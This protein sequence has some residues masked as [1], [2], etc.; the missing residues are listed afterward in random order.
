V[1]R[2]RLRFLLQEIDLPQGETLIGRS[3]SCQVTIEDP[4]VSRQH[5]RLYIQGTLAT[6]ED[7]GS[8]NGSMV[9]GRAVSGSVQ[10]RDGDRIRIGTQDL[11]LCTVGA[12]ARRA[13]GPGTRPTGFMCHCADCSQ[14]YPAELAMCPR[15]GATERIDEDT[16][17]G[18]VGE[19]QRNWSLELLI[20]VLERA[21]SLGRWDDS[22]RVLNRAKPH[23]EERLAAS[24]PLTREQVAGLTKAASRLAEARG[25]AEWG[26]WALALHAALGSVPPPSV[27]THLS[28]LPGPERELLADAVNDVVESV[29][30][31]G[32]PKLEDK[33]DF[34]RVQSLGEAPAGG[35][36]E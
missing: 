17:S 22:E 12:P 34:A 14:P 2:Y 36:C 21:V 26:R 25:K 35:D 33:A 32:G 28:T 9:N 27:T 11:V 7:L 18:V 23:V 19:A 5:G 20:E 10:V 16:I 3:A 8:R 15:C 30:A 24:Q 6:F 4:L 1:T 13:G 29:R 31:Q